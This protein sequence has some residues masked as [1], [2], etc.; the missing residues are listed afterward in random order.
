MTQ[1]I[2]N[3][4]LVR[5][6]G[7]FAP[8][9]R[10]SETVRAVIYGNGGTGKTT[11]LGTIPGRGLIIDI[12]QI[13]GGD[14]VLTGKEN[15]DVIRIENWLKQEDEKTKQMLKW[16]LQEVYD[17][18]AYTA[19]GY[20]WVA[21][22]SLTAMTELAIRKIIRERPSILALDP[23]KVTQPEWGQVGRLVSE[24]IYQFHK[25]PIHIIW[26]AQERPYGGEK[27]PP[28]AHF[29]GPST[30]PAAL[31]A[32]IPPQVLV[33]RLTVV[34]G[35][36]DRHLTVGA[37]GK[38]KTKIRTKPNRDM[39]DVILRPNLGMILRYALGPDD[40]IRPEE[41][42]AIAP[43]DVPILFAVQ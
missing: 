25:L 27:D 19:H 8:G 35:S 29:V 12:P 15:I 33:G 7:S 6:P 43:A 14:F 34:E 9:S 20:K 26:T 5:I 32:L 22:D 38:Y 17:W 4:P 28:E 23:H 2:S 21:I 1:P 42:A 13:E 18:L 39:P 16:G 30:S 40:A 37:N 24:M 41:A 36:K 11:L 3:E 31:A 10:I